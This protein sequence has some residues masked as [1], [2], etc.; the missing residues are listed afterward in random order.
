MKGK[1]KK[2]KDNSLGKELNDI[3]VMRKK[4]DSLK[5]LPPEHHS[6]LGR[7]LLPANHNIGSINKEK[8]KSY[9]KDHKLIT[10]YAR[11]RNQFQVRE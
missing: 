5:R 9:R 2:D 6:V 11:N 1:R 7:G 10:T 8:M 4:G 3:R